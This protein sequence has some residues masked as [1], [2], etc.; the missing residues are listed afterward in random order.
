[1]ALHK[2]QYVSSQ[3]S[4]EQRN[5]INDL[6]MTHSIIS[7]SIMDMFPRLMS[8]ARGGNILEFN[9]FVNSFKDEYMG[10]IEMAF[11]KQIETLHQVAL[12]LN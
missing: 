3:L 6:L 1:M 8:I 12:V 7:F 11:S 5:N 9:S 2:S 10:A 4:E